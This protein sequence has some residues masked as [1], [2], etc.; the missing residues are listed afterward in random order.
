MNEVK[1]TT[2]THSILI[3]VDGDSAHVY[4]ALCENETRETVAAAINTNELD[5]LIAA[6]VAAKAAQE[7]QS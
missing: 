3:D 7:A 6:L 4:L 5:A 2:S 1:V